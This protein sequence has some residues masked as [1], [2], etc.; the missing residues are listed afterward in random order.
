MSDKPSILYLFSHAMALTLAE[1]EQQLAPT[2][3]LYG[4]IELRKAGYSV[5]V[6]DSRFLGRFGKLCVY[7]RH[8]GVFLLD[9][10]TIREIIRHDLIIVKDDFSLLTTL[11]AKIFR[12]KL[13]YLDA[14]FN[15]PKKRWRKALI[16]ASILSADCVIAYSRPQID[17]WSE[18]LNIPTSKFRFLPYTLDINFYKAS[19][20]G[21]P[22]GQS[23]YVLAIG[24]DMGRDFATLIKAIDGTHIALKLI[25][26]PYLLPPEAHSNKNV[27]IYE[28]VSYQELFEL[29]SQ[30][31]A[32]VV[33]LKDAIFYPSG[34]RA[35][36]EAALLGK[37]TIATRTPILEEYLTDGE[38]IIYVPP[39]DSVQLRSAIVDLAQ[40]KQQREHLEKNARK[41][42]ATKFGMDVFLARLVDE[43]EIIY[44]RS[45]PADSSHSNPEKLH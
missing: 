7:F 45:A 2:E 32:V 29:Y 4:L 24:R 26:L 16:K 30:A 23:P 18:I 11:I 22:A 13:I 6:C 5:D 20:I 17:L 9:L 36:F 15:V 14:M 39:N 38:E 40:Q 25:T 41:T 35:V 28:R 43:I 1:V 19:T 42:V 3:R 10:T 44:G 31:T 8:Y 12:K 34:I 37:A 21:S 27:T 33:P